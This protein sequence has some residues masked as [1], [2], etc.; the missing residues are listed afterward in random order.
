M[1]ARSP[2]LQ[3]PLGDPVTHTDLTDE[4]IALLN[5]RL[6]A[7]IDTAKDRKKDQFEAVRSD[8]WQGM[9]GQ[10]LTLPQQYKTWMYNHGRGR[11][12]DALTKY[13]RDW[14]A[15]AVV[16]RTKK[17]DITALIQEQKGA[18]PGEAEM[19]GN[20]QWAVGQVMGKMTEEELHEAEQE[21]EQWNR[22]RPPLA[23]QADTAA[24][25]G[26]QYAREFA[27]MM[28]KQCGMQV[29]ILE[30]W[31]NK[32]KQVLV[33]SHDFNTELDG[34]QSFESLWDIQKDWDLYAQESFGGEPNA[35]EV[36][37]DDQASPVGLPKSKA[38]QDPIE[39]VTRHNGQPWLSNIKDASLR[40][41]KNI[42]RGY[43]TCHY[44]IACS[45]PNVAV[46][47]GEVS[48]DQDEYIVPLYLPP[49]FK[50]TDPSKMHKREAITLLEFWR[51]HQDK[52]KWLVFAFRWW[53]G[54][55]GSLQEPVEIDSADDVQRVPRKRVKSR[56]TAV[57]AEKDQTSMAQ[58]AA[59]DS[60]DSDRPIEWS[61][62]DRG[63]SGERNKDKAKRVRRVMNDS[64]D[65]LPTNHESP[66]WMAD[67]WAREQVGEPN[68]Q[69]AR[70][71]ES[72]KARKHPKPTL[73]GKGGKSMNGKRSSSSK[74]ARAPGAE[75]EEA[76]P[77]KKAW[78]DFIE[79]RQHA[80]TPFHEANDGPSGEET[81]RSTRKRKAPLPADFGV[82]P[83]THGGAIR[84]CK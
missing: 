25:K 10:R 5:S 71:P 32:D 78:Q 42:V 69:A 81:C 3:D 47:W 29:V 30:A 55:N 4:E 26:K 40:L 19:L 33:S 56:G 52:D 59:D 58:G 64:E 23:V 65:K 79:R 38:R 66:E 17:A 16:M 20:Y 84:K 54:S 74:R 21:A 28:W 24:R 8:P 12:Q 63:R 83:R 36:D 75:A 22:E 57:V 27:S 82:S 50:V 77:A 68:R 6:Q 80:T 43:F 41:L 61:V 9:M 35:A 62:S 48:K 67:G 70:V 46:P 18:K 44:R 60:E 14:T 31:Q 53:R 76:A 37:S 49:G 13:Q 2:S 1:D 11:A 45:I 39:L 51:G 15:Q 34:G 73:K 7:W 72:S